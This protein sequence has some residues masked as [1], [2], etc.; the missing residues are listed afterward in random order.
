[1][2]KDFDRNHIA[3]G[4]EGNFHAIAVKEVFRVS[5]RNIGVGLLPVF[6]TEESKTLLVFIYDCFEG[7]NRRAWTMRFRIAPGL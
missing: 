3:A 4:V 6:K 7:K 5:G 1:M 2:L